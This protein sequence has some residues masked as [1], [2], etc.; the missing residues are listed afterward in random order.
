MYHV[1]SYEDYY[2]EGSIGRSLSFGEW[3]TSQVWQALYCK[4]FP[5]VG[6]TNFIKTLLNSTE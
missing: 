1:M 5:D 4:E 6:L 3:E 2:D